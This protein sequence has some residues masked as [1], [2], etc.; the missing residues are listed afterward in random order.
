[1]KINAALVIQNRMLKAWTQ[2]Q[3]AIASGLSQRTIQRVES[4]ANA[5]L[6]TK[7]ALAATFNIDIADLE[8]EEIE[9]VSKYEYKTVELPFKLRFFKSGTPDVESLLNA[10]GRQGWQLK[11]IVI[12]ASGFGESDSMVAILERQAA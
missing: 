10:E 2:E 4:E 8:C 1:M 9:T 3:L 7:K 6:E 11:Q 12:P 5:S